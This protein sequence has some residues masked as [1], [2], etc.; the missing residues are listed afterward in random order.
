MVDGERLLNAFLRQLE[1]HPEA[2]GAALQSSD[3]VLRG[4]KHAQRGR[5]AP[6]VAT[7]GLHGRL[8]LPPLQD[9][10]FGTFRVGRAVRGV[11]G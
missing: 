5:H 8:V 11:G 1:E 3:R 6:V 10:L 7:Q 2:V 4:L 9:V